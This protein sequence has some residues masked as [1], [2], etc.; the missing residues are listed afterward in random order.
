M[1]HEPNPEFQTNLFS[2]SEPIMIVTQLLC[3]SC[4][5]RLHRYPRNIQRSTS[6]SRESG[7]NTCSSTISPSSPAGSRALP[8]TESLSA[9]TSESALTSADWMRLM[10]AVEKLV[11]GLEGRSRG[12]GVEYN[13]ACER[14]GKAAR[15]SRVNMANNTC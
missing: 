3:L 12:P 9:L 4:P 8:P 13:G 10:L 7:A 14:T 2:K 6:G 15:P 11:L 5:C 1:I